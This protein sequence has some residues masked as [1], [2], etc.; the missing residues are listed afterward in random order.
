MVVALLAHFGLIFVELR[1]Q[2]AAPFPKCVNQSY[3]S[4]RAWWL[5]LRDRLGVETLMY[6]TLEEFGIGVVQPA[7]SI[8]ALCSQVR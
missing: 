2:G 7:D 1:P 3:A 6:G 5:E 4:L 8:A